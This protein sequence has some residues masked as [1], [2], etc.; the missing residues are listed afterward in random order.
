MKNKKGILTIILILVLLSMNLAMSADPSQVTYKGITYDLKNKA[1]SNAFNAAIQADATPIPNDAFYRKVTPTVG[2]Y[3]YNIDRYNKRTDA[4]T[5]KKEILNIKTGE[6]EPLS[7]DKSR[8]LTN[9]YR[10]YDISMY[11]FEPNS[12]PNLPI[13]VE[14]PQQ[15][16]PEATNPPATATPEPDS[17]Q[18][19]PAVFESD[20]TVVATAPPVVTPG[21]GGVRVETA[22]SGSPAD[23]NAVGENVALTT[24]KNTIPF[25]TPP[26]AGSSG[27]TGSKYVIDE[28]LDTTDLTRTGRSGDFTSYAA[29]DGTRIITNKDG[30]I[31]SVTPGSA[32]GTGTTTFTGTPTDKIGP[33]FKIGP[34]SKADPNLRSGVDKTTGVVYSSTNDGKSWIIETNP[35]K[36]KEGAASA[37]G[38]NLDNV[39]IGDS[40]ADTGEK[41]VYLATGNNNEGGKLYSNGNFYDSKWNLVGT[42]SVAIQNGNGG[43]VV[44]YTPSA[45]CNLAA[46][47]ASISYNEKG[48]IISQG[49]DY[50]RGTS[51]IMDDMLATGYMINNLQKWL[52]GSKNDEVWLDGVQETLAG[53]GFLGIDDFVSNRICKMSVDENQAATAVFLPDTGEIGA[54]IEGYKEPYDAYVDCVNASICNQTFG[55]PSMICKEEFC[56]DSNGVPKRF[57]SNAY[58]VSLG[59]V[60]SSSVMKEEKTIKFYVRLYPP[61]DKVDLNGDKKING[62]DQV[63]LKAGTEKY[64]IVTSE[65]T[66]KN[67]TYVCMDF[68]GNLDDIFTQTFKNLFEDGSRGNSLCNSFVVEENNVGSDGGVGAGIMSVLSLGQIKM[69]GP[70]SSFTPAGNASG[71]NGNSG[72]TSGDGQQRPQRS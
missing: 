18:T 6:W 64:E 57:K 39:K 15:P 72:G 24:E 30:T 20:S 21:P 68:E 44:Q 25:V 2:G 27:D 47:Y 58:K 66:N 13:Y 70:I 63:I 32:A 55:N 4:T 8:D 26:T 49:T 38:W 19:P 11:S 53:T 52:G 37:L 45:G 46:C 71:S 35:E 65:F 43:T 16:A 48:E 23:S 9:D 12:G 42:D 36:M 62:S 31:N 1:G 59:F 51:A 28:K 41:V 56:A 14:P 69:S 33:G 61:G 3:D 5:K 22:E 67:Y 34:K 10:K 40:L 17:G 60:P 29:P 7:E 50:I 54:H